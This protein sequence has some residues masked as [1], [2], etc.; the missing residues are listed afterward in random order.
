[1]RNFLAA[2]L[3]PLALAGCASTSGDRGWTGTGA[4]PFDRAEAA[5]R[6]E[7]GANEG[8]GFEAC[9][10]GKGWTRPAH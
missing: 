5:C 7:A 6:A 3:I 1:M 8:A 10:A 2:M 9:M 4:E